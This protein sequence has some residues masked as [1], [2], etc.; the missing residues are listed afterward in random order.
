MLT[1]DLC[2][3]HVI[4]SIIVVSVIADVIIIIVVI[5][6]TVPPYNKHSSVA[7]IA[8][9]SEPLCSVFTKPNLQQLFFFSIEVARPIP[10]ACVLEECAHHLGRHTRA[11]LFLGFACPLADT[12]VTAA[13][14]RTRRAHVQAEQLPRG[15]A[16]RTTTGSAASAVARAISRLCR[17]SVRTSA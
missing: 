8:P 1:R 5:F 3:H 16:T 17:W 10:W 11:T 6:T 7:G 13:K 12:E 14:A 9:L 2:L 15:V 4:L